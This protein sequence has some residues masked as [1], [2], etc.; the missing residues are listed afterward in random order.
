MIRS[1]VLSLVGLLMA[2]SAFATT[3]SS[4]T[5]IPA[6]DL[7]NVQQAVLDSIHGMNFAQCTLKG[8]T[9][10]DNKTKAW[11]NLEV[12]LSSSNMFRS[13]DAS[14]PILKATYGDPNYE[15]YELLITTDSSRQ[16]VMKLDF[17]AYKSV[18]YNTGTIDQP[19]YV[20]GQTVEFSFSCDAR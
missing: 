10:T 19:N 12:L 3:G 9:L 18:R 13:A 6:T 1:F 8:G 15:S 14:Q 5:K 2:G 4:W 11:A 7:A 20:N 17:T 16:S